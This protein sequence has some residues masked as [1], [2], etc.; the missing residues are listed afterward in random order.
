MCME[1]IINNNLFNVKCVLTKKDITEG[2]MYK[3]FDNTFDGMLFFMRDGE[4]HFWMKN[5]V[6]PL[7]IIFIKANSIYKIHHNC[8][9]CFTNEC[10]HYSGEGDLVLE[11]LGGT[12]NRYDIKEGDRVY[13]D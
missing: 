3:K 11:V 5:C 1:L 9:P 10:D 4:H 12:C 8:K 13:F 7:D 2:M 6:I